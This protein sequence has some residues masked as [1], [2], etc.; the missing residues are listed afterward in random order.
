MTAPIS[1]SIEDEEG[2]LI[3]KKR[4]RGAGEDKEVPSYVINSFTRNREAID[5]AS[6]EMIHG[7]C[8]K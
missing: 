8:I 2:T 5:H 1:T 7:P 6:S 4:G 3:V